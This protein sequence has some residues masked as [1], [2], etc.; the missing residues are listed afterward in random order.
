MTMTEHATTFTVPAGYSKI[1]L[2]LRDDDGR[3]TETIEVAEHVC[4]PTS[5]ESPAICE[6][7]GAT[8][9]QRIILI[10]STEDGMDIF[11]CYFCQDDYART[12]REPS[13]CDNP[14]HRTGP[15]PALRPCPSCP[16]RERATP[17]PNPE[18]GEEVMPWMMPDGRGVDAGGFPTER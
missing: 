11:M 8:G 14:W 1:Q 2:Q 7:C 9:A 16:E 15:T 12:E 17:V 13:R 10:G 4:S 18:T 6:T 3:V 5:C